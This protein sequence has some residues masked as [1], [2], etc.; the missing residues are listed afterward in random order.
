M[1]FNRL[2]AFVAHFIAFAR[3]MLSAIDFNNQ[4]FFQTNNIPHII[5]EELWAAEGAA[6]RL[7]PARPLH[8]G[9]ILRSLLRDQP[10][11][12]YTTVEKGKNSASRPHKRR[13]QRISAPVMVFRNV[14]GDMPLDHRAIGLAFHPY[15]IPSPA[16]P[17]K[18]R[19]IFI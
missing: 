18:G 1:G 13:H 3:K 5:R 10:Y 15:P 16:L 11:S 19:E 8:H 4:A 14:S 6:P 7:P 9:C 12:L 2:Q 17:L